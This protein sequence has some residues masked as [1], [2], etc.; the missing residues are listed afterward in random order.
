MSIPGKLISGD[1]A[2]GLFVKRRP[3]LCRAFTRACVMAGRV[4]PDRVI[5]EASMHRQHSTGSAPWLVIASFVAGVVV[6]TVAGLLVYRESATPQATETGRAPSGTVAAGPS[7]RAATP[8]S[9]LVP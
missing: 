9:E 3:V 2:G 6:T 4:L 1:G 5:P 8:L 7:R